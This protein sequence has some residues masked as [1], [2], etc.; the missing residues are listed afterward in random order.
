MRL[1][2]LPLGTKARI[3]VRFKN[4]TGLPVHLIKNRWYEDEVLALLLADPLS[5]LCLQSRHVEETWLQ[6]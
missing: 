4:V 5:I 3:S 2:N 6:S 1:R